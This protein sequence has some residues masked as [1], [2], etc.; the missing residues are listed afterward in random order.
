MFLYFSRFLLPVSL[1]LLLLLLAFIL[2][3]LLLLILSLKWYYTQFP[4]QKFGCNCYLFQKI[5]IY[6]MTKGKKCQLLTLN[7]FIPI[8][9]VKKTVLIFLFPQ[10]LMH[11]Y[12][13]V[14]FHFHATHLLKQYLNKTEHACFKICR[15]KYSAHIYLQ[16][17]VMPL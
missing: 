12:T 5:V 9:K 13:F 1:L 7:F 15:Y 6:I 16:R 3:L 14:Y 17:C 2:Q 11:L 4:L 8:I 10:V